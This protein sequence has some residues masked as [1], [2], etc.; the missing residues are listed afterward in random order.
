MAIVSMTVNGREVTGEVEARTLLS[1]FLRQQIGLT[2]THIGCDAGLCG[3]CVVHVNGVSVKSCSTLAVM[4]DGADVITIEGVA[5]ATV[6][7]PIQEAFGDNYSPQC[8]YC[9]SGMI[10]SAMDLLAHNPDP[11]EADVRNWL[12][13]NICRCAGDR[14]IVKAILE[15][16]A[17]LRA[18]GAQAAE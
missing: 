12:A 15:G 18:G 4:A 3:A 1:S 17:R 11:S 7:H 10:M 2:G 8:D 16:A 5:G 6:L 14:N 9:T 13:G